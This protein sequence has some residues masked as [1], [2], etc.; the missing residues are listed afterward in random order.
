MPKK[1]D[2]GA[3][4][5]EFL[6]GE[7]LGWTVAEVA[8]KFHLRAPLVTHYVVEYCVKNGFPL[9]A[10][11]LVADKTLNK[12]IQ[13]GSKEREIRISQLRLEKA[14]LGDELRF[15]LLLE[16]QHR[17]IVLLPEDSAI[18]TTAQLLAALQGE[19]VVPT[20]KAEP[21]AKKAAKTEKKTPA[22]G[23]L[24]ALRAPALNVKEIAISKA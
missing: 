13:R 17:M 23:K 24:K 10:F 12:K 14:D 16:P 22:R 2:V 20:A 4:L 3:E 5:Y 15:K 11:K 8:K 21:A 1:P 9:P 19:P 7:G 18:D 6:T